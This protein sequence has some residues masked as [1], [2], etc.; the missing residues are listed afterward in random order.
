MAAEMRIQL[1]KRHVRPLNIVR[2]SWGRTGWLIGC[3]VFI[4]LAGETGGRMF[5]VNTMFLRCVRLVNETAFIKQS[6]FFVLIIF[7]LYKV[8]RCYNNQ[9]YQYNSCCHIIRAFNDKKVID[10]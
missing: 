3:P 9:E 1:R 10:R 7:G 5:L 6:R 4:W 8:L 2:I